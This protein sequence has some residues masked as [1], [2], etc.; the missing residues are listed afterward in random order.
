MGWW[1]PFDG[2]LVVCGIDGR[3]HALDAGAAAVLALAGDDRD[4]VA[5]VRDY[6][7]L[8][9]ISLDRAD[10][11]VRAALAALGSAGL[12]TFCEPQLFRPTRSRPVGPRFEATFDL[13][14]LSIA[15]AGQTGDPAADHVAAILAPL[16]TGAAPRHLVELSAQADGVPTLVVDGEPSP[17]AGSPGEAAGAAFAAMLRLRRPDH[18]IM[19]AVHGACVALDGRALL[20]SAPCGY[21]KSTLATGLAKRGLDHYADD[22][23]VLGIPDGRVVPWPAPRSVK[24]GSW[25]ALGL[26][27]AGLPRGPHG[28]VLLRAPDVAWD[29]PAA[30]PAALAFPRYVA[31]ERTSIEPVS[32]L[33]ALARLMLDRVH[34]G[35]PLTRE[36]VAAFLAV[37]ARTPA[38]AVSYGDRASGET[39]IL[40]LLAA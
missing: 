29:F 8:R 36:G 20:L 1:L 15:F 32:P 39:A 31:G 13:G 38:Y 24:P 25:A 14:G 21:G 5:V 6:A 19:G 26:D 12:L 4:P 2:G 11:D 23:I 33:R 7:D 30:M 17:A 22:M 35:D 28:A 34:L 3:L 16:R 40:A 37:L 10:P 9:G 27:P 18:V